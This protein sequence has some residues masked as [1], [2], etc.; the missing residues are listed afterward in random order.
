MDDTG[1]EPDDSADGSKIY[2]GL[3]CGDCGKGD[4]R[5]HASN[6]RAKEREGR[7][8]PHPMEGCATMFFCGD[9][10]ILRLYFALTFESARND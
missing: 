3:H 8:N 4:G 7:G 6:Y 10:L 2:Q 5:D 1:D 9:H